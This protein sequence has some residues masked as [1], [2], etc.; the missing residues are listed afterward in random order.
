MTTIKYG[1]VDIKNGTILC[2]ENV[3][4]KAIRLAKG[5]NA[6]MGYKRCGVVKITTTTN[7]EI[8]Q[9]F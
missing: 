4:T 7:I 8:E 2:T 6:D 9:E 5:V 1:V 3:K